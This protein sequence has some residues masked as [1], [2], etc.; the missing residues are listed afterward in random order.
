MSNDLHWFFFQFVFLLRSKFA[1]EEYL[2]IVNDHK[3][4]AIRKMTQNQLLKNGMLDPKKLLATDKV[5]EDPE[6]LEHFAEDFPGQMPFDGKGKNFV[7]EPMYF[8]EAEAIAARVLQGIK[9]IIDSVRM[10]IEVFTHAINIAKQHNELV[11]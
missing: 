7:F 11:E 10:G 9:P 2:K 6:D 1:L 4:S 5:D 3:V 8:R